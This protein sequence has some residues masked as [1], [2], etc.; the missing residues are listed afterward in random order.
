MDQLAGRGILSIHKKR[1]LR[2]GHVSVK[3][4]TKSGSL[5]SLKKGDFIYG[6]CKER[7]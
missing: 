5:A 2:V 1:R 7:T 3:I 4:I 6:Q